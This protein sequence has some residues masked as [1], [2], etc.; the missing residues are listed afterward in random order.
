MAPWWPGVNAAHEPSPANGFRGMPSTV[1][2]TSVRG[3][4][5]R[6]T[7]SGVVVALVPAASPILSASSL[8]AGS[9]ARARNAPRI[10]TDA[11]AS[12]QPGRARF[13]DRRIT[14]LPFVIRAAEARGRPRGTPSSQPVVLFRLDV[15]HLGQRLAKLLRLAAPGTL[16]EIILREEG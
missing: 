16:A 6:T 15:G 4:P 8:W 2:S 1:T 11:T 5:M 14:H 10:P 3:Q 13:F 7:P 9:S 12:H